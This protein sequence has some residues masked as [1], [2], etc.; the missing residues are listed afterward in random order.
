[1]S[2]AAIRHAPGE[3]PSAGEI[4]ARHAYLRGLALLRDGSAAAAAAILETVAAALPDH[5]GVRLNLVRAL[6]SAG[7]HRRALQAA[8][9][10]FVLL[11]DHAEL[12]FARG[13]ALNALGQPAAARMALQRAVAADPSHAAAHLNLGNACADLDALDAAEAHIRGALVCDPDL[14]EAHA[15]LGFVLASRGRLEAG[16]AAC[17]AAIAR[18]P[19]FAQAHWNLATAALLAGDFTRGFTE[20]EWRKRHDRYRRDFID[21]PGP[22]WN[23]ADPA[24]G[25]I[26]VHA[27]QGLG[28]TIQLARYLPLIAARGG[29]PVLACEASLVPWLATLPGVRV[30]AKDAPLP[31]YDA[32]IEQMSLPRVFG[33]LPTTIP[34]SAGYLATDPARLAA[35]HARLP[36]GR[37][38]GLAWA[39]NPL[40][41]NDRRRSL[42]SP[43]LTRLVAAL[44]LGAPRAQLVNLQVGPAAAAAGVPDLSPWLT[45]FAETAALV[46]ALDV[47]VTVDTAVA[48]VA[49]A[50]GVPCWVMLPFAPDW[51]WLLGREDSPW[52]ASL[53]LFRQPAPGEWEPVVDAIGRAL[54]EDGC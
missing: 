39:G 48:H 3:S 10:A 6:L 23:G 38:I 21:L 16:M 53:R 30:V 13:T 17:D 46:A 36:V 28:D 15:S 27:E 18:R 22:V 37:R 8:E 41:G 45:D 35:W 49:G 12:H 40:H 20:Y 34:S 2:V 14:P 31:G 25:V 19:D 4:D 11:P 5:D 52:Y 33:T 9:A 50:L 54:R 24:G 29:R 43:A 44:R 32:W 26:L 7:A 42:P 1:M 47:V 51:R